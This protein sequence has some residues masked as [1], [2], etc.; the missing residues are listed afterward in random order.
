MT[1][2]LK[3]LNA[4]PFLS[5]SGLYP[6]IL[7]K[8]SM[9]LQLGCYSHAFF[10]YSN[11]MKTFTFYLA[12][13][14][15]VASNSVNAFADNYYFFEYQSLRYRTNKY[16]INSSDVQVAQA[17]DDAHKF[18]GTLCI[19]PSVA[20][21]PEGHEWKV[22]QI[23]YNAFYGCM[24]LEEVRIPTSIE[25]LNSC[26]FDNCQH[27]KTLTLPESL[28]I[29]GDNAFRYNYQLEKIIIPSSVTIIGDGAFQD[30]TNLSDVTL[31]EGLLKIGKNAFQTCWFTYIKIPSTVTSIGEGAFNGTIYKPSHLQIVN[32]LALEPPE[33]A[34]DT[35]DDNTLYNGRLKV[36]EESLDLYKSRRPWCDF[37][38]IE[39]MAGIDEVNADNDVKVW[40]D[41]GVIHIEGANN[42]IIV[43]NVNGRE[44]AKTQENPVS[45]LPAGLYLV[46]VGNS[47][48]KV[49]L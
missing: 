21:D 36:P 38:N 44:I 8:T 34:L 13:L 26:A 12:L 15:L 42:T 39:A 23:G 49:V 30:C 1:T 31:S 45:G 37:R 7:Y 41:R 3:S 4:P 48:F 24:R 22:T 27:L 6:K 33:A 9:Q 18:T 11:K 32:C 17:V 47:T 46:K 28:R 10:K 40:N 2:M 25:I 16:R 14:L 43:F 20:K 19:I 29:I 5:K 35:F